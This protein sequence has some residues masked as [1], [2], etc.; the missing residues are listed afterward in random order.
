MGVCVRVNV[1]VCACADR[2]MYVKV[3][4]FAHSRDRE[5]VGVLERACV[6]IQGLAAESQRTCYVSSAAKPHVLRHVGRSIWN[7]INDHEELQ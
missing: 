2:C 7:S 3:C 6:F 5:H 1:C 4:V